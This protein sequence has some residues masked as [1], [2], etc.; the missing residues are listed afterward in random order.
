MPMFLVYE[1]RD[2]ESRTQSQNLSEGWVF[3][4]ALVKEVGR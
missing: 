3:L 4:I 1:V 2:P